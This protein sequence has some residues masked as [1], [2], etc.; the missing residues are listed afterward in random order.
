MPQTPPPPI[1]T[2]TPFGVEEQRRRTGGLGQRH[3]TIL[4][5]I[6]G[7]RSVGEVMHLAQ[8]AGAA[9]HHFEDLVRLG[10]VDLPALPVA[11]PPRPEPA[12]AVAVVTVVEVPTEAGALP[13]PLAVDEPAADPVV[14]AAPAQSDPAALEPVAEVAMAVAQPAEPGPAAPLPPPADPVETVVTAA[15]AQPAEPEPEPAPAPVDLLPAPAAADPQPTAEVARPAPVVPAPVPA[16]PAAAAPLPAVEPPLA[17][18]AVATPPTTAPRKAIAAAAKAASAPAPVPR[19]VALAA[20]AASPAASPTPRK[21]PAAPRPA[22]R[23]EP[24]VLAEVAVPRVSRAPLLP[25]R[26]P[27]GAPKP[28]TPVPESLEDEKVVSAARRRLLEALR[29]DPPGMGS[30]LL[31]RVRAARDAGTLIDLAL[32]IERLVERH[33]RSRDGLRALEGAREVLGLGNT[34]VAEDSR[35]VWLDT[36]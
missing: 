34:I 7:R 9:A 12:D 8:Q 36:R 10:Y 23:P 6:D 27:D 25:A 4:F 22:P 18:A 2:K 32:E 1:P 19:P 3:R 29:H 17:V 20:A 11:E 15:A 24:P 26:K 28:V 33:V 21:A 35:P 16:T 13:E 5:L 30:R 14:A 31:S